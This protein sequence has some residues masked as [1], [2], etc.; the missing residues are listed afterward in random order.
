MVQ[1]MS[2]NND[3]FRQ[4]IVRDNAA[5]DADR[6]DQHKHR[7]IQDGDQTLCRQTAL[8]YGENDQ[9]VTRSISK[10]EAAGQ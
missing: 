3:H 7:Q 1:K 4:I 6:V 5:E 2:L 9:A 10:S 8:N